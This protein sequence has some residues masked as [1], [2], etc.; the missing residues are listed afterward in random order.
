MGS[1]GLPIVIVQEG[2][3]DLGSLG[4]LVGETLAGIEDGLG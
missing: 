3:Y 2:G 1:L 4:L